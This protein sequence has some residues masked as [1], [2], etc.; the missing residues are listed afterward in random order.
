MIA[1][2]EIGLSLGACLAACSASETPDIF[3]DKSADCIARFQ[4]N[5]QDVC[6]VQSENQGM[7]INGLPPLSNFKV[8]DVM[9]VRLGVS[10]DCRFEIA[11][12]EDCD[13]VI[14]K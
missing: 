9:F 6:R 11:D 1:R 14:K 5:K 13:T 2:C 7:R 4:K 3:T 10:D 12:L 8:V